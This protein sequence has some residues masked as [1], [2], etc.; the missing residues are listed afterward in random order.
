MRLKIRFFLF[1]LSAI[2]TVG[3]QE[4]ST[5]RAAEA[6]V[7]VTDSSASLRQWF[8]LI[9][10]AG[11]L[12]SYNP[13]Q[14]N[15][16]RVLRI[17]SERIKVYDLLQELLS[18]YQFSIIASDGNK[19]II[20][21]KGRR[22]VAVSGQVEEAESRERL[23]G[24]TVRFS[25]EKG[26]EFVT[27]ADGNG[28][29]DLLLPP[30]RYLLTISYVGYESLRQSLVVS[31]KL[32]TTYRLQ[33][34]TQSLQEVV[35]EP[36]AGFD[37]LN[38]VS[39]SNLL[40]FSSSD[41]FSQIKILP[42][43]IGSPA[44]GNL[45]VN[46]GGN[47]ENLVLLDGVPVYHSNHLSSMLPVFNGDAIKNV[48][49][50]KSFFPANFEG[51]LS[52]VTDV[53]LK[54]GNK[55]RYMQTL[56]LDM[57]SA[58]A[59]L[60]GPI[61]KGRLSYLVG[62]RRSWLDFFDNLLSE[63]A[64]L[65]HSFYDVNA[66]LSY[67]IGPKISL[68]A[69]LYRAA[70]DYYSS[71]EKK[72]RQSVLN[73]QNEAY[74]L[75]LNARIGKVVNTNSFYYTAYSNSVYAPEIGV[76]RSSYISG[77]IGGVSLTSDFS[78]NVDNNF[79][80]SSGIK[81]SRERFDI[82]SVGDTTKFRKIP[83]YQLSFFYSTNVRLTD[84]LY[85]Q[86]GVNFVAYL[87]SGHEN[88]YSIQPRFSLKYTPST[89]HM[90]Y[91]D[92]SRMEQFYHYL[93][94]DPLPLPTD[95]RMPS[96]NGFKPSTSVHYEMGWKFFMTHGFWETAWYYK[97]RY[98]ILAFRPS[99]YPADD[100]WSQYIMIGDGESYGLKLQY[101]GD[102]PRFAV[103]FSYTFSRSKEWFSY[104]KERGKV[105][106]DHD[107]PHVGNLALTYRLSQKSSLSVGGIVRSGRIVSID[108]ETLPA[109]Q[110]FRARRKDANFRVDASYGYVKQFEK[111]RAKLLLRIGL[112]NIIGNP[113]EEEALDFY[114]INFDRHCLP[115]GSVTFKF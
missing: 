60:E 42:G 27:S 18:D 41:L 23:Y 28:F 34:A 12:L 20:R 2:T 36:R 65:N 112:Y 68:Q 46:G 17:E 64:R 101:Y 67:D 57:P 48:A 113:V 13:S 32:H 91:A 102:W 15:M 50:H 10:Q 94:I 47:D 69:G 88:Y 115:Y 83:V 61:V 21:I 3:A 92:F 114:S 74:Y 85:A 16:D 98:N 95:F 26:V 53:K 44:N 6:D 80:I 89:R 82:A 103:Q 90:F 106:S 104:L 97:R 111:N 1:L 55:E 49:F 25:T 78:L 99:V 107:V 43:V 37:E 105:P 40:A 7:V 58:S 52:S 86:A 31:R 110:Q 22:P 56:S 108:D 70:D 11:V 81:A 59:V 76:D 4:H 29:F 45:Q 30:D 39:P 71:T 38:E 24:A 72:R 93:R 87:P 35:I 5:N 75:K 73:W 77:R 9:E 84:R 19:L 62:A 100:L 66:K 51:R 79:T 109:G 96:I 33:P 54:E 8:S 63:N 14:L